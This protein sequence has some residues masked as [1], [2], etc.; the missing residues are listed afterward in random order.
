MFVLTSR[1][2]HGARRA[3]KLGFPTANIRYRVCRDVPSDGVYAA[4]AYVGR[5]WYR[6]VVSVG[7]RPMFPSEVRTIEAHLLKT[8]KQLYGKIMTI[9]FLQRLRSQR[10]FSS[11]RSLQRAVAGDIQHAIPCFVSVAHHTKK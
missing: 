6:T 10:R 1:V 7:K 11:I 2:V 4:W 8:K 3:R 9:V 5:V